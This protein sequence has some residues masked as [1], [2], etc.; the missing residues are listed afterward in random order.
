M[1]APRPSIPSAAPRTWW[2]RRRADHDAI[3]S[4]SATEFAV[5]CTTP[6]RR[7]EPYMST[8]SDK[9]LATVGSAAR[10]PTPTRRRL[11]VCA[12]RPPT[13]STTDAL[14]HAPIGMSV[15]SGC[16]RWPIGAPESTR[17]TASDRV[18]C[19]TIGSTAPA[20][21]SSTRARSIRR[22][23]P[24][25]RE[26]RSTIVLLR[27]IGEIGRCRRSRADSRERGQ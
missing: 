15:S 23:S 18:S 12:A 13:T 7:P 3:C 5:P 27:V 16:N 1:S 8:Q 19:R 25:M 6:M 9:P 14:T 20:G 26:P 24:C 11:A 22:T 21:A 4:V 2:P 10:I 17:L